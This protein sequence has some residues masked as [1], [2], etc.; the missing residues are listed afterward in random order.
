MRKHVTVPRKADEIKKLLKGAIPRQAILTLGPN[1]LLA[2][3]LINECGLYNHVF[4]LTRRDSST[5]ST[6]VVK[7]KKSFVI[8]GS[9]NPPHPP[10]ESITAGILVTF[11]LQHRIASYL[12]L[13][14]MNTSL[15]W[16]LAGLAPWRGVVHANP[17]KKEPRYVASLITKHELTCG[18]DTRGIIEDIFEKGKMDRIKDV[19]HR[20]QSQEL[21]KLDAGTF[22]P[23][24]ETINW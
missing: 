11:L 5:D 24:L 1:Q 4:T 13:C 22:L 14:D 10:S 8:E 20:N 7:G 23:V 18:E 16:L 17:P 12:K 15:P 21:S 6:I 19:V 2:L 9:G 3:K